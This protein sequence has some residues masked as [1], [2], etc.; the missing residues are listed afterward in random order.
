MNQEGSSNHSSY[1]N[2]STLQ[3][4]QHSSAVSE[5]FENFVVPSIPALFSIRDLNVSEP[6][7]HFGKLPSIGKH[8]VLLL[9]RYLDDKF[10]PKEE[11]PTFVNTIDGHAAHAGH[12]K[13]VKRHDND[14]PVNLS[15]VEF[16]PS[17]FRYEKGEK[18]MQ[19]KIEYIGF[20]LKGYK[21]LLPQ[22]R[23]VEPLCRLKRGIPL[24]GVVGRFEHTLMNDILRSISKKTVHSVGEG[25]D[26]R[27]ERRKIAVP[28]PFQ[29]YHTLVADD[30]PSDS[31]V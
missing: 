8:G 11:Y 15:G 3:A 25:N 29:P 4:L 14:T 31:Q 30:S 5:Q 23:Q 7:L 2:Q 16:V 20:D 10:V 9:I 19:E 6:Y 18:F 24:Q 17:L 28:V 22:F 13:V 26:G 1:L 27:R 21:S 12:Y